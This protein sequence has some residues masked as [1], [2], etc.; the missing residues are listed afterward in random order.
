MM[1]TRGVGRHVGAGSGGEQGGSHETQFTNHAECSRGRR[2][3]GRAARVGDGTNKILMME[4]S[5]H[6]GDTA[7]A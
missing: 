4:V 3:G 5:G 1:E 7:G 6:G 2:G